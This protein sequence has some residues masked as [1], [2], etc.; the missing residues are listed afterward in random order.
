M[1][2]SEKQELQQIQA[3]LSLNPYCN[4]IELPSM[5]SAL[6]YNDNDNKQVNPYQKP[7]RLYLL[8]LKLFAFPG[9]VV[10]D[11]TC[12]VGSLELAAMEI[13]APRDLRFVAFDKSKYQCDN[14]LTRLAKSCVVASTQDGCMPDVDEEELLAKLAADRVVGRK[15]H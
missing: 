14:A 10:L 1:Q 15:Q 9:S 3:D 4:V 8:L 13:T 12:G 7:A 2:G 11:L 6:F 5:R